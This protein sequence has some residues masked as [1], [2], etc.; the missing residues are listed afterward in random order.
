MSEPAGPAPGKRR[1]WLLALGWILLAAS[2]LLCMVGP[3][4]LVSDVPADIKSRMGDADWAG[5]AWIIAGIV[6]GALA[7]VCFAVEWALRPGRMSH[8]HQQKGAKSK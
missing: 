7:L 4:L 5:F 1:P 3:R 2:V 8:A 6:T